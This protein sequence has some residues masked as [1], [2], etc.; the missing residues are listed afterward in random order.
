M[1]K[2]SAGLVNVGAEV[3]TGTVVG[4]EAGGTAV[5]VEAGG[6]LVAW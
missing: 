6:A 2:V 1:D 3:E 4:V 5:G